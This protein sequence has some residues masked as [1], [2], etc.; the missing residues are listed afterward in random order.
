LGILSGKK[1]VEEKKMA[2]TSS[3]IKRKSETEIKENLL[4][5]I[6]ITLHCTGLPPSLY[7][8]WGTEY[9]L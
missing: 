3:G 5:S 7:E 9:I 6:A 8:S 4:V 2:F 1:V